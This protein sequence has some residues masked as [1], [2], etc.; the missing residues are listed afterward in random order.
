[1]PHSHLRLLLATYPLSAPHSSAR[2]HEMRGAGVCYNT[3]RLCTHCALMRWVVA[4]SL[5]VRA[6]AREW[7]MLCTPADALD[8]GRFVQQHLLPLLLGNQV[9]RPP[10]LLLHAQQG[11]TGAVR[12]D[13]AV[14]LP[15]TPCS[16]PGKGRGPQI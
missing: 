5:A 16:R 14:Q 2:T 7:R 8:V 10:A 11:G 12:G 9:V 6:G 1:M 3:Q 15:V 13:L 4:A